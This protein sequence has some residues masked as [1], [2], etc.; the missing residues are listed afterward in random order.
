MQTGLV[1]KAG[2][3]AALAALMLVA[4]AA[5][6]PAK[7]RSPSVVVSLPPLHSLVAAVM[8]DTG[9]PHLMLRG[10]RS[11]HNAALRPSDIKRLRDASLVV[12][13]GPTMET[14]LAKAVAGI[15]KKD[16]VL[17]LL[18]L[19]SIRRLSRRIGRSWENHDHDHEAPR[20]LSDAVVDPHIWLSP[21]N[22]IAI[23]RA[24]AA[25]LTR[26]DPG[27]GVAY[28]TNMRN[29]IARVGA[30]KSRLGMTL[31]PVHREPYLVFHDAY[32]YFERHF[33]LQALGAI[34]IDPDRLPGARRIAEIRRQIERSGVHCVFREPQ[35]PPR[36]LDTIV[37]ETKARIGIID[38]LGAA[39]AP[40]PDLWFTLM[41]DL[42]EALARCLGGK[43]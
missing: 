37:R 30:L 33:A 18:D 3:A 7:A 42:G 27:N 9:A 6:G 11:P 29:L 1:R 35:F 10:A 12:W 8:G 2:R 28:T 43:S 16:A 13:V 20:G 14:F 26:L 36:L 19:A 22:A 15:R 5:S 34:S 17:T 31:A 24:S 32:Q 4:V 25:A 41:S 40:G 38:P 21:E 23:A 39:L